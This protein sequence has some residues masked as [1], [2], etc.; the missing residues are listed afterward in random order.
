MAL[1]TEHNLSQA[2]VDDVLTATGSLIEHHL[3]NYASKVKDKLSEL[4]TDGT[5]VDDILFDSFLDSLNSSSK[6][7]KYYRRHLSYREPVAVRLGTNKVLHIGVEEN[8]FY[9]KH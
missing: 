7:Y 4:G 8:L 5:I 3:H 1:Q 2:A 9:E 6:C